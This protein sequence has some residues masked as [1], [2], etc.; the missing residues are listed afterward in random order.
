M[1]DA[2]GRLLFRVNLSLCKQAPDDEHKAGYREEA[3]GWKQNLMDEGLIGKG[4]GM[5]MS[6][7]L[8]SS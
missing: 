3:A 5:G 7:T 1:G 8:L 6:E 4:G 2:S